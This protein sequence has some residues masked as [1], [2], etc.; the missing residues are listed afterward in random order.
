MLVSSASRPNPDPIHGRPTLPVPDPSQGAPATTRLQIPGI[1]SIPHP[2][3]PP[4]LPLQRYAPHS[5]PNG[6]ES[7]SKL[8]FR[9][10]TQLFFQKL[11]TRTY[12]TRARA[13]AFFGGP[14]AS[15]RRRAE[16]LRRTL[17][18]YSSSLAPTLVINGLPC[19]CADVTRGKILAY[20][21]LRRKNDA[22][23]SVKNARFCTFRGLHRTAGR[24][25]IGVSLADN[26]DTF[27]LKHG[28][29]PP[30]GEVVGFPGRRRWNE[31]IASRLATGYG[32]SPVH[33]TKHVRRVADVFP[34]SSRNGRSHHKS[35]ARCRMGACGNGRDPALRLFAA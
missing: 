15:S 27:P 30:G 35:E 5:L 24:H 8:P 21:A 11:I 10:R 1:P 13:W 3:P 34:R 14:P 12:Q 4:G 28:V 31:G 32:N 9:L 25:G 23:K 7:T 33:L 26:R 29:K 16:I 2:R 22:P 20:V 6:Q 17:K 19:S 18:T